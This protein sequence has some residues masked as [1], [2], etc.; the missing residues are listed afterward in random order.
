[1]AISE[2]GYPHL[3]FS[4]SYAEGWPPLFELKYAYLDGTGWQ[5]QSVHRGFSNFLTVSLALDG[6]GKPHIG[7]G[8]SIHP[9][10]S[11]FLY[12]SYLDIDGWHYQ[13]PFDQKVVNP[14]PS[15]VL[16]KIGIPHIAYKARN[17][18]IYTYS[19][20]DFNTTFLPL[21]AK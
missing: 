7:Y 18:L 5:I 6:A 2:D 10:T 13:T 9:F 3:A 8:D 19:M 12:Y 17:D 21:I 4:V 20:G 16:D 14:N 1:L 15:L 11:D